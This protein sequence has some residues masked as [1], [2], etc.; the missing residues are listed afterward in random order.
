MSEDYKDALLALHGVLK[1][2]KEL[3]K[4]L[5][6][7]VQDIIII[8]EKQGLVDLSPGQLVDKDYCRDSHES[9]TC[10]IK[11][12]VK[13]LEKRVESKIRWAWIILI[14]VLGFYGGIIAII[15]QKV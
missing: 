14:A 4:G 6:Q 10:G 13:E 2:L 11:N 7:K 1:E 9:L 12:K 15:L 3:N 5:E 8:L